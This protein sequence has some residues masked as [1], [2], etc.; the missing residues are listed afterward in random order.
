MEE[1]RDIPGY[2]GLYQ[3]SSIGRV[4]SFVSW[5]GKVDR[6]MVGSRHSD[7]YWQVSLR[8]GGKRTT[9]K[10]HVFVLAAFVGPVPN[11]MEINHINGNKQDNRLENLEYCS[12][13]ENLLHS[14]RVLD[15]KRAH[16]AGE[17]GNSRLIE[18]DVRRIRY[19]FGTGK[20]TKKELGDMFGIR[21]GTVQAIVHRRRWKH[22]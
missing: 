22:I 12:R 17:K 4:R 2:E 9:R 7:G 19:L 13:S 20:Y 5:R 6:I 1:W 16:N 18:S 14:Y 11:G 8:K 3:V 15:R 10:V 21:P